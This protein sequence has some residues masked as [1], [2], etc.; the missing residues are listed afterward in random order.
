MFMTVFRIFFVYII[1]CQNLS[2]NRQPL[3]L[4]IFSPVQLLFFTD[5]IFLNSAK[6]PGMVLAWENL[7]EVLLMLLVVVFI[8][9]EVFHSLLFDVIAHLSITYRGLSHSF[10]T[11]DPAHCRVIRDTFILTFQGF[12]ITVLPRALRL[13]AGIFYPQAFFT[14]HS[15]PTLWTRLDRRYYL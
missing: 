5:Q 1:F 7:Q 14:L 13:W 4:A 12:Y 8:S 9:L 6:L 11:F 2:F 15:F 10:Y 3:T